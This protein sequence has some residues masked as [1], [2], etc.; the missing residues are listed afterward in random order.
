MHPNDVRLWE[1]I[2]NGIFEEK[3]KKKKKIE[4]YYFR[5]DEV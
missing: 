2:I 3:K 1:V 4:L 5:S